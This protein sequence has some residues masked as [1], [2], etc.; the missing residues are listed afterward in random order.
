[1]INVLIPLHNEELNLDSLFNGIRAQEDTNFRLLI[2]ENN[3]SDRTLQLIQKHLGDFQ[4][5]VRIEPAPL[6][7]VYEHY[8]NA[9]SYFLSKYDENEKWIILS[10]DDS[11][12]E[13]NFLQLCESK[14]EEED[15]SRPICI[16]PAAEI[17][18]Q[19]TYESA[20]RGN[21]LLA[22]SGK[23]AKYVYFFIPRVKQPM[24]FF[25]GMFS[26]NG[27]RELGEFSRRVETFRIRHSPNLDRVPAAEHFFCFDLIERLQFR[28]VRAT[29]RYTTNNRMRKSIR[30]D[31]SELTTIQKLW[32]YLQNRLFAFY[33][34]KEIWTCLNARRKI[35]FVLIS[36]VSTISDICHELTTRSMRFARVRK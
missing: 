16:V 2:S 5:E 10:A 9:I 28:E 18:S 32:R 17:F 6:K 35:I 13:K 36:V 3:S 26:R 33:Y 24:L 31:F 1:M 29:L 14:I 22:N 21:H 15:L 20:F 11:W 30:R 12:V 4:H 7:S 25:Y 34:L 8:F 19:T 27:I 23:L